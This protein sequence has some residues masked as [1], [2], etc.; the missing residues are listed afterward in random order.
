MQGDLVTLGDQIE[1]QS[2]CYDPDFPPEVPE[3]LPLSAAKPA[4]PDDA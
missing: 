4:A 1:K 3:G 2:F